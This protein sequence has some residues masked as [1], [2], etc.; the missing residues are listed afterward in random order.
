MQEKQGF[1]DVESK[2]GQGRIKNQGTD[3]KERMH[4]TEEKEGERSW[5]G[6]EK[7]DV[8]ET[9]LFW[10]VVWLFMHV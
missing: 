7:K 9:L 1:S 5:G 8:G 3:A 4:V 6:R 2:L 10:G